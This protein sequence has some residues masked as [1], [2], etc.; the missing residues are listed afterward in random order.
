M[1]S[2]PLTPIGGKILVKPEAEASETASGILIASSSKNEKPQM[3]MVLAVGEGKRDKEGNLIPFYVKVGQKVA[4]KKYSP[5]EFEI[6][7]EDYLIMN[8]EDVL[9]VVVN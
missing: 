1:A 9:A 7:G 6:D 2:L 4:F 5:D 3:G 8:E